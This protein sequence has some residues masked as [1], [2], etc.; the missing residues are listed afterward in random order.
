MGKYLP[1][2]GNVS[3]KKKKEC[4]KA[5]VFAEFSPLI[6][7]DPHFN[8]NL[9]KKLY[10]CIIF[11]LIILSTNAVEQKKLFQ[12]FGIGKIFTV[13]GKCLYMY[14]ISSDY[15]VNKCS[16]TKK[17]VPDFRHRE[18][19]HSDREIFPPTHLHYDISLRITYLKLET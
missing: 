2:K 8:H 6:E 19:I 14:Y 18:N 17:V 5:R 3:E 15:F 12:I 1:K 9:I 11:P 7:I 16:R 13:I 10:T 4:R